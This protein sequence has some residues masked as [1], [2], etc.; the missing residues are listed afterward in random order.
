MTFTHTNATD[1]STETAKHCAAPDKHIEMPEEGA[2]PSAC[3]GNGA[4]R[5]SQ[6]RLIQAIGINRKKMI[7]GIFGSPGFS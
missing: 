5:G 1:I 6:K 3:M 7:E 2:C 4:R